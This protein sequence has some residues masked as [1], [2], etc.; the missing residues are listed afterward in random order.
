M[1]L[2]VELALHIAMVDHGVPPA[3]TAWLAQAL[4]L[5]G[6]ED[7]ADMQ[8]AALLLVPCEFRQRHCYLRDSAPIVTPPSE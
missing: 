1:S 5:D 3:M 2:G 6:V 8:D 7:L 4:G